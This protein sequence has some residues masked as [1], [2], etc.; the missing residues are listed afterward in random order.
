MITNTDR[1]I[2]EIAPSHHSRGGFTLRF[3]DYESPALTV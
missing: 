2:L 3:R 1:R